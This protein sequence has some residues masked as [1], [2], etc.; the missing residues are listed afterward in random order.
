MGK[1]SNN[2]LLYHGSYMEV[3]QVDLAK[4]KKGLDF[5]RGFYVTSSLEQAVSFVPMAI[6]KAKRYGLISETFSDREGRV[7]VFEYKKKPTVFVHI[8][9]D[10]DIEWLH[11]IACNRNESLF[12]EL[13]KKLQTVD[14]I[15]GKIADDQTALT[16]NNYVEGVYGIPGTEHVDRM[17]IEMLEPNRLKDQWCFRTNDAISCLKF[18]RSD[19][20]GDLHQ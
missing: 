18:I 2:I 16:L 10:A 1:I 14:I 6:K 3:A 4:C 13:R 8:F 11:F 9:E 7:S 19:E 12:P 5:G 15:G 20:Y 17:V